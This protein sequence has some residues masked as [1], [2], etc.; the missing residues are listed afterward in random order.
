MFDAPKT[1]VIPDSFPLDTTPNNSNNK[2]PDT[3]GTAV[4]PDSSPSDM[5]PSNFVS[6]ANLLKGV[7][8]TEDKGKLLLDESKNLTESK[9]SFIVD[10]ENL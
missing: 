10:S 1:A 9:T 4:T 8:N 7:E 5:T 3:P 2:S 6:V